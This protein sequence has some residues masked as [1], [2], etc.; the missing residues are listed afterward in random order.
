VSSFWRRSI[1]LTG[2]GRAAALLLTKKLEM[3]YGV[4]QGV[5]QNVAAGV[6][7]A[8]ASAAATRAVRNKQKERGCDAMVSKVS[9]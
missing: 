3:R 7:A 2:W 1:S 5:R 8:A 4:A 6:A 9:Q